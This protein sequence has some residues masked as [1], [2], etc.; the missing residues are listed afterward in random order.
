MVSGYPLAFR[1]VLMVTRSFAGGF[2]K[3]KKESRSKPG[4]FY[5]ANEVMVS[6]C[7]RFRI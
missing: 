1:V 3:V 6:C 2:T 7:C 5:Y 4:V